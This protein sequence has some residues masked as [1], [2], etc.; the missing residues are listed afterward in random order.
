MEIEEIQVEIM[1]DGTLQISVKG[2]K[3]NA[4]LDITRDL[5]Q[6]LGGNVITREMSAEALDF[7]TSAEQPQ[8]APSVVQVKPG[9]SRKKGKNS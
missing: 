3:G 2:V 5:E 8:S 7:S 4:C 1:P 9:R 6:A